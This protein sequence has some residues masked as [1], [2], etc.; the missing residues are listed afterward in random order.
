VTFDTTL[1]QGL[2]LEHD[3][4]NTEE[5]D[6]NTAGDYLLLHSIYN[7]RTDTSNGP[8]E[9]PYLEWTLNGTVLK[10]GNSGSY[11]RNANDGDGVTNSSHSSAGIIVPAL[12]P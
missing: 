3:S 1:E 11:N 9:N 2:D 5:I 10:Y 12:N 8:R 6:I 7:S 4:I